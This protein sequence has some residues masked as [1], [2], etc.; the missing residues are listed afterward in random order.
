MQLCVTVVAKTPV[1]VLVV[2]PTVG[3]LLRYLCF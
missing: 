1:L 2:K 3:L